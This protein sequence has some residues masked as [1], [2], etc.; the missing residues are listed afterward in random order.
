M[1]AAMAATSPAGSRG[2]AAGASDKVHCY[3]VT[4]AGVGA[5]S[6]E[7]VAEG[8]AAC[9][10]AAYLQTWPPDEPIVG[11]TCPAAWSISAWPVAA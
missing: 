4:F 9:V 2:M 3:G 10:A 7:R 1:S 8:A 6:S 11:L 5:A